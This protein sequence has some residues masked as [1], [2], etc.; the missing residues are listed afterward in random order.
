M[1]GIASA[2][3]F[4]APLGLACVPSCLHLPGAGVPTQG[5]S[6]WGH[7]LGESNAPPGPTPVACLIADEDSFPLSWQHTCLQMYILHVHLLLVN[8]VV[9][10]VRTFHHP[11]PCSAY[12]TVLPCCRC[13]SVIAFT[14]FSEVARTS[15]CVGFPALPAGHSGRR[16]RRRRQSHRQ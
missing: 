15:R 1:L 3:C 7:P 2:A 8:V 11:T 13:S 10:R 16:R 5:T 12:S 4:G 6:H 14:S 9:L